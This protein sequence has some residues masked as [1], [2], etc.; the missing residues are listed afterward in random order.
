MVLFPSQPAMADSIWK[1]LCI[2]PTPKVF[3]EKYAKPV[4]ESTVQLHQSLGPILS[5]LNRRAIGLSKSANFES[6][7]CDAKVMQYLSPSSA[8]GYLREADIYSEQGQQIRVI[9]VCSKGLRMADTMDEHYDDLKRAKMDAEERQNTRIDFVSQLPVDIV[10]T[11][12]I[13]M[14]MDD[15]AISSN[16][17]N[18]YLHVSNV[19]RDRIIQCFDGLRFSVGSDGNHDEDALLQVIQ[20]AQ[21]TKALYINRHHH[22][23]WLDDLLRYHDFCSLRQ[24]FIEQYMS[25]HVSHFVWALK[26]ISETLAHLSIEMGSGLRLS[27]AKIVLTCP[28]L[29]SLNL[30]QSRVADLSSLPMTTWPNLKRLSIHRA[31]EPIT[32]DQVIGIW[33]RFPSLNDLQL[34]PCSDMQSALIV[35]DYL[36]SINDLEIHLSDMGTGIIFSDQAPPSD[37]PG[38]T[39]ISI[40]SFT[41][42]T[43]VEIVPILK[44]HRKTLE[45]LEWYMSHESDNGDVDDIQYPR[46]KKLML[47]RSGW[48]IPRNALLLEE[49]TMTWDAISRHPAVLHMIPPNLKKLEFRLDVGADDVDTPTLKRYLHRVARYTHLQEL[50]VNSYT[51]DNIVKMADVICCLDQLRRLMIRV[52]APC[53]S[54]QM[55]RFVERL[56]RGCPNLTCLEINCK[57]GLSTHSINALKQLENLK[58]CSFSIDGTHGDGI[59]EALETF[60]QLKWIRIYPAIP[61]NLAG[62]RRLKEKRPDMTTFLDKTFRCF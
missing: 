14:L 53:D 42:D 10:V 22:A 58:Q 33:R 30:P 49:L 54:S 24:L 34:Q 9:D 39:N 15:S 44:Q 13:P 8:L 6:A 21:H 31:Q 36:P 46:L 61:S 16:N 41:N 19:W 27:I 60:T 47:E 35:S 51:M 50:I 57:D 28:N 17:P 1:D 56:G 55:N 3:S 4:Q 7:L 12:L 52:G 32:C 20:F 59:W 48:W 26:S 43:F 29:V 62:I 23:T 37:T 18:P 5:A 11:K 45:D 40:Q 2:Q 38:I 25:D